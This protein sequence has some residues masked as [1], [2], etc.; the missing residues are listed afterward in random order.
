MS[1]RSRRSARVSIRLKLVA[2]LTPLLLVLVA[3]VAFEVAGAVQEVQAVRRQTAV[4]DASLGPLG[5]LN[6][7]ERERNAASIDLLGLKDAVTLEVEDNGEARR[8]TDEAAEQLRDHLHR[9][10]GA[11]RARYV[12]GLDGLAGLAATREQID[13][14]DGPRDLTNV[15]LPTD[16]FDEYTA[17]TDHLYAANRQVAA[18][19]D[20]APIRRGAQL[21]LLSTRQTDLIAQLVRELLLAVAT[22]DRDGLNDSQEIRGVASLVS[23]LR[24]NEAQLAAAGDEEYRPFVADL[25][26]SDEVTVFPRVVEEALATGDVDLGG[27][28]AAA[29]GGTGDSA[30]TVFRESVADVIRAESRER[31]E[32]AAAEV[33]WLA[34]LAAVATALALAV[35]LVVARSIVRAL[36]DLTRQAS[37]LAGRRLPRAVR[38]ILETPLGEDVVVPQMA[39]IRVRT[40]DEAHDVATA[41]TSVQ[42]TAVGL[43]VEQ[44]MLRRNS[45]DTFLNM[46][47]RYQNLLARQLEFITVLEAGEGDP[48]FL[49]KLFHLDHLATRMRRNAESLLVLAGVD[50]PRRWGSP[51]SIGDVVRAAVGEV[52]DFRRV[53]VRSLTPV[54]VNGAAASDLAHLLAELV[55]NALVHSPADQVVAIRG[56]TTGTGYRLAVVD[57]G[58]GMTGADMERANRR[59]VGAESFTVAPSRSLGHYVAGHLAARHGVIIRLE[60]SS[61]GGVAALVDLPPGLT[62]PLAVSPDGRLGRPPVPVGP[63]GGRPGRR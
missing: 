32:A 41:L 43:A 14:Y 50:P 54:M 33:R 24:T 2:A 62:V 63:G 26:A 44:A 60:R 31:E 38:A 1:A 29:T 40:S 18:A 30:Y 7:I 56:A 55:E 12:E 8:L 23:R 15:D 5:L 13:A 53:S 47:R 59:L 19:I 36:E 11:V 20:D 52:E 10:D 28:L 34:A 6:A 16:V 58:W 21:A 51:V 49:G 35:A 61:G 3:A 27:A 37:D 25:L 17:V 57:S 45:A 9:L 42:R 4:V 46:G 48:E 22:G 39:P